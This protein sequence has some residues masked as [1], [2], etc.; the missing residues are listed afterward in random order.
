MMTALARIE[1]EAEAETADFPHPGE[2]DKCHAAVLL[3]LAKF[4]GGTKAP[5]TALY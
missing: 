1:V 2:P 4:G 5:G 3:E